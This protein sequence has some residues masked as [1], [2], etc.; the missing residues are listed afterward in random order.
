MI[1]RK[2]NS[3]I[4]IVWSP[5]TNIRWIKKITKKRIISFFDQGLF[6]IENLTFTVVR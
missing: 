5:E 1:L 4:S 6:I 3:H 2:L